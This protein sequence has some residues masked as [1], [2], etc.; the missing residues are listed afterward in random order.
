[1]RPTPAIIIAQLSGW[2]MNGRSSI[3][4]GLQWPNCIACV[5]LEREFARRSHTTH[6]DAA[7]PTHMIRTTARRSGNPG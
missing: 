1:M 5:A 4:R 3:S 6:T 7:V 2:S